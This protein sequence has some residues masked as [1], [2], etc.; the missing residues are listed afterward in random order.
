MK[1]SIALVSA[2]IAMAAALAA[3]ADSYVE[4]ENVGEGTY[5]AGRRCSE[6]YLQGKVV[7]VCRDEKMAGRMEEI[8]T[9]FK[10]K[11]FVLLGAFEATPEKVTYPVYSGASLANNAPESPLYVVE[12]T[13]RIRYKGK[14]ERTATEA[15]VSA[16][17]DMESPKNVAQWRMFLDYELV[18]LPGRAYL[19]FLEFKKKLPKDAKEY[20]VKFAELS[21][22]ENV[23]KLAE[24]VKFAR[25]AKDV[26]AFD[27]KKAKYQQSRFKKMVEGAIAKYSPLKESED[28]RVRQEAKNALADLKWTLATL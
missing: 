3:S 21:K 22:T 8:W 26:R 1:N 20:E 4:W 11:Q 23:K 17:T 14:D 13:G 16:L 25:E 19:R 28:S 27:P 7:L 18:A 10:T 2:L 12:E 15:L 24:L 6:G 9:S 5:V